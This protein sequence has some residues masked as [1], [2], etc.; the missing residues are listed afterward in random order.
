[1]RKAN[2]STRQGIRLCLGESVVKTSAMRGKG[3]RKS[4]TT[5]RNKGNGSGATR[6]GDGEASLD[7]QNYDMGLSMLQSLPHGLREELA[8][9]SAAASAAVAAASAVAE[10]AAAGTGSSDS[11]GKGV[12]SIQG[13]TTGSDGDNKASWGGGRSARNSD[14]IFASS[15]FPPSPV[16]SDQGRRIVASGSPESVSFCV[17]S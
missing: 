12:S 6:A 5:S 2:E 3:A 1:M 16:F 4:R 7:M 11:T 15:T 17:D 9:N 14:N 10:V 8:T 13:E